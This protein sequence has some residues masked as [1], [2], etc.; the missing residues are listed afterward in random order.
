LRSAAKILVLVLFGA[1]AILG[2]QDSLRIKVDVELVTLDVYVDDQTG[3][4]IT[5]LAREDFMLFEDGNEREIR[6]FDS[7]ENPYNILLLFDRSASAEDQWP[8]LARA[9]ARFVSQL[10]DRHRVALAAFDEKPEM[11]VNWSSPSQ[12][13]RQAVPILLEN[14]G[15]KVYRAI[16]WATEQLRDIKGRKGVIVLTD[17]IDNQ[18]SSSLVSF[19]KQRNPTIAPPEAD[20]DFQK[21]LR[22][23]MQSRIPFYFVAVNTDQ[24]PDPRTPPNSFD[25]QQRAAAR[26]RME[27]VANQSNGSLRLPTEL[28]QLSGLYEKIGREL[29]HSYSLGFGPANAARDGSLHRVEVRLRDKSLRVTQSRESYYAR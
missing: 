16:E 6:S 14:S 20:R 1:T 19:D 28:Q 4:P 11:L 12:F 29:G 27:I 5:S 25:L 18:L 7:A 9:I 2:T 22:A 26:L 15:T 24:N 8:F 17:G 21:M 23:V 13:S 10:E 3:K